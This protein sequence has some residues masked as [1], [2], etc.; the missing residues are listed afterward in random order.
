MNG[1]SE[2]I[3][4]HVQCFHED[5]IGIVFFK[6]NRGRG[7]RMVTHKGFTLIELMVVIAI[8]AIIAAIAIPA[9]TEQVRK[10]RRA[11]AM[12]AVGQLQLDLE[13][14]RADNPSFACPSSPCTAAGYPVAPVSDFYTITPSALTAAGFAITATP[15]GVQAGDRCGALTANRATHP[16]WA[17]TACN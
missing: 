3:S 5:V 6:V 11:D 15:T 13:K 8:V 16:A 9:Y 10:G 4:E 17:T 12:R 1:T 14:W 2:R 7:M